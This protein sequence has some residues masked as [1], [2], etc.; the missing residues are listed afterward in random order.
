MRKA[1]KTFNNNEGEVSEIERKLTN[2]SRPLRR[3]FKI[4][5][6][7]ITDLFE[8]DLNVQ[9]VFSFAASLVWFHALIQF[10]FNR[11]QLLDDMSYTRWI[12]F[13]NFRL[14]MIMWLELFSAYLLV[15]PV[16]KLYIKRYIS[17]S[18]YSGLL[19]GLFV[20]SNIFL[21]HPSLS[22]KHDVTNIGLFTLIG[23]QLRLILKSLA[24]ASNVRDKVNNLDTSKDKEHPI[25]SLSHYLYYH[26]APVIIYRDFYPRSTTPI[27]WN[28]ILELSIHL[29][30]IIYLLC[31]TFIHLVIPHFN[32]VG[33][34]PFST[35]DIGYS[36]LVGGLTGMAIQYSIGYGLLHCCMN[37]WA[38]L[39][40]FGDR[41]FCYDWWTVTNVVD[42]LRKWN[43][44]VGDFIFE[45]VYLP[46]MTMTK[47][48]YISGLVVYII[49]AIIH[50]YGLYALLGFFIPIY[51][52]VYPLPALL[53][54]ISTILIN[55]LGIFRNVSRVHGIILFHMLTYFSYSIW[56]GVAYLEFYARKNCPET[57]DGSWKEVLG[58]SLKFP[59][60]L[61][62]V[63]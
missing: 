22:W 31:V 9:A 18:V 49:S 7:M 32:R 29:L 30:G 43:L 5:E 3:D 10:V 45:C 61:N 23:E 38:E 13:H 53:V 62:I 28:R 47:N 63:K 56:V 41:R 27:N 33:K 58:L 15:Y 44:I 26:F 39:T 40:K 46:L 37:I 6:S 4:R 42:F 14:L 59:Q 11:Q 8:N 24:F 54:D 20:A 51:T 50:D 25:C 35:S 12:L 1:T 19:F 16:T 36:V 21:H 52:F 2:R 55:K 48:R 34:E 57:L 60:C 17:G